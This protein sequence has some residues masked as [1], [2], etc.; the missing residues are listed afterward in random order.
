MVR[1]GKQTADAQL[2]QSAQALMQ[3]RQV[4]HGH[5]RAVPRV[6][7]DLCLHGSPI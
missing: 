7:E 2:A 5:H 4:R 6:L 3:H 1:K